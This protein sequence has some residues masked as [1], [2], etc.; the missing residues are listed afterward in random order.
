VK[1]ESN[2]LNTLPEMRPLIVASGP[3]TNDSLAQS[4]SGMFN[5]GYS[6]FSDA[7]CP[8][9]DINSVNTNDSN[10][11]K[12]NDD[13]YELIVDKKSF[14]NFYDALIHG[15]FPH[16]E[17]DIQSFDF[18]K[19]YTIED[20]AKQGPDVLQQK[21]FFNN[22]GADMLFLR[23]ESAITDGF[24]L[25]GCTTMLSEKSQ[26]VAFSFLPGLSNCKFIRYGR[27]HRNTCF[28][29]PGHLD[30]FYN[31]IGTDV[32]LI[33][34]ISGI[35]GYAAAIS[36]GFIAAQR[37]IQGEKLKPYPSS[38]MM[39]AL[40]RYVSNTKVTDFQPMGASFNLYE[41]KMK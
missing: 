9:I 31:I 39:G 34:Q 41:K 7:S 37:I 23:R 2:E 17:H 20:L 14:D 8:I 28:K 4:I 16:D 25:A 13:L 29:S 22:K 3:L 35:D 18:E 38:C 10:I 19:I 11:I 26:R 1:I 27:V 36:S 33:G 30:H 6:Q 32:Y 24:I 12:I 40:A 21:R 5:I 15:V